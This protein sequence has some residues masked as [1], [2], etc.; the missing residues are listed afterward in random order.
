VERWQA[1]FL[2]FGLASA[3]LASTPASATDQN[4][5]LKLGSVLGSEEFC[6]L[7]YDQAAIEGFIEKNVSAN[8]MGF[9]EELNMMTEGTKAQNE[10]MSQSSKTAHCAQI[11]R[12]AKSYG[13]VK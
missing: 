8:D 2:G 1:A 10:S 12:V 13:F 4:L 3:A 11:R 5:T 6:G 7:D 9:A